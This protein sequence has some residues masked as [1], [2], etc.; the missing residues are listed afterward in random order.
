MCFDL[1]LAIRRKELL[2]TESSHFCIIS[3]PINNLL[4]YTLRREHKPAEG[5]K[6]VQRKTTKNTFCLY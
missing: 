2:F 4:V 5:F 3:I 6:E 1:L